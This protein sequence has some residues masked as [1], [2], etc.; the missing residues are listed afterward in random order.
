MGWRRAASAR[1]SPAASARVRP[2]YARFDDNR[3]V[4]LAPFLLLLRAGPNPSGD[5][6]HTLCTPK[7]GGTFCA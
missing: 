6:Q 7:I 5:A 2:A 3:R 1:D 4:P